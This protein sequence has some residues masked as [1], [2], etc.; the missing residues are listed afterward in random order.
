ML[1]LTT[2]P[3]QK[4][5]LKVMQQQQWF[6]E[7]QVLALYRHY[8]T[9]CTCV[10]PAERQPHKTCLE[11]RSGQTWLP[12]L[13]IYLVGDRVSWFFSIV[14]ARLA[15]LRTFRVYLAFTATVLGLQMYITT[16]ITYVLRR[17][18]RSM[19]GQQVFHPLRHFPSPQSSLSPSEKDAIIAFIL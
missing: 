9:L 3:I 12:I 19:L 6:P 15:G 2:F 10:S 5:T 4:K 7:H 14:Y 16:L 13:S 11:V 8:F 18:Q 1:A 17:K